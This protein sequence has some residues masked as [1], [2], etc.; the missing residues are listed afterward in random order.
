MKLIGGRIAKWNQQLIHHKQHMLNYMIV[1]RISPLP[2]NWL[3]NLGSP[4]LSVPFGAFFWGTFFGVAPP[5]FIHVQA[6]AALDR[7]SSSDKLELV[8]PINIFCLIVVAIVALIPV[9][10][11]RKFNATYA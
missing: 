9:F 7:L 2:P 1:L 4:H 5:S 8:T 6:G 3:V 11:R 10:V